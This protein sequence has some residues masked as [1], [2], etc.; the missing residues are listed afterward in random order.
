MNFDFFSLTEEVWKNLTP[1]AQK[2]L[3]SSLQEAN[4]IIDKVVPDTLNKELPYLISFLQLCV[5]YRRGFYI[6]SSILFQ[7]LLKLPNKI[8]D[9]PIVTDSDNNL[10]GEVFSSPDA[11]QKYIAGSGNKV[12]YKPRVC[13]YLNTPL[14]DFELKGDVTF[15]VFNAPIREVCEELLGWVV[16]NHS[17]L[18]NNEDKF[19]KYHHIS[20]G[21]HDKNLLLIYF[22][23][24]FYYPHLLEPYLI[25]F[26]HWFFIPISLR[27]DK[28]TFTTMSTSLKGTVENL[29]PKD[30]FTLKKSTWLDGANLFDK[31]FMSNFRFLFKVLDDI[32]MIIAIHPYYLKGINTDKITKDEMESLYDKFIIDQNNINLIINKDD[33]DEI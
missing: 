28:T 12:V 14:H 27:A 17:L 21:S 30:L 19:N 8:N 16:K 26:L 23:L 7:L 1:N 11:I 15:R 4:K 29:F 3:G 22:Y 10:L 18:V 31:Y 32:Y 13:F 25:V 33:E 2:E 6:P 5:K 9:N 24:R 20:K